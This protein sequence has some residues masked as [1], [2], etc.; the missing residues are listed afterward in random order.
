MA[1]RFFLHPGASPGVSPAFD[2][3]WEKTTG[4]FRRLMSTAREPVPPGTGSESLSGNENVATADYDVLIVQFIS[5]P[6]SGAQNVGGGGA[7]LKGQIRASESNVD[8]DFRAQLK[9]YIVSRDGGTVRGTLLDFDASVLTSE[10]AT[11]LTNRKFPL[12]SPAAT[13]LV[14]ASDGDRIVL[15]VGFRSHNSHTTSRTGTLDIRQS[16]GT[17]LAEDETTTTANDPWFELSDTL[18]FEKED[19]VSQVIGEVVGSVT[20]RTTQAGQVIAEIV[21]SLSGRQTQISQVFAEVCLVNDWG[22][23]DIDMEAEFE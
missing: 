20:G 18:T 11:S 7:T 23:W 10:F 6:L 4:A 22:F 21:G 5:A 17:D 3:G 9:A 1:T 14:A 19:D 2:A 16:A 12:G 15:E 13:S 8:A